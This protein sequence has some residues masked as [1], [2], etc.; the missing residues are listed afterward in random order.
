ME[1]ISQLVQIS[2]RKRELS[3][4]FKGTLPTLKAPKLCWSKVPMGHPGDAVQG[5]QLEPGAWNSG[6]AWLETELEDVGWM[7]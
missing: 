4:L 2:V 1:L 6:E 7:R 5:R 3:V